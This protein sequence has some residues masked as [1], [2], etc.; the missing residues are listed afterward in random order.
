MAN[1]VGNLKRLAEIAEV[2]LGAEIGRKEISGIG[3]ETGGARYE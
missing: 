1:S 2:L 3:E